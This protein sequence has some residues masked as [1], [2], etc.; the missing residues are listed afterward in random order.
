MQERNQS[1]RFDLK[2]DQPRILRS[3]RLT[4]RCWQVLGEIANDRGC[5]RSD[6]L[7]ELAESEFDELVSAKKE[8]IGVLQEVKNSLE[9]GEDP[10]IETDHRSKAPVRRFLQ[11]LIEFLE[12]DI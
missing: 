10:L 8:I 6:L 12:E 11:K 7:E 1:G 3:I 2:G 5:S 4:D 9:P